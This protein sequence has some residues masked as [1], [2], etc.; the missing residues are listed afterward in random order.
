MLALM[1]ANA[2]Q[3]LR[4]ADR[5]IWIWAVAISIVAFLILFPMGYLAYGALHTMDGEFTLDAVQNVI[6]RD[7]TLRATINSVVMGLGATVLAVVLAV[8]MAWAVART[9]MPFKR[10][11][12]LLVV[13]SYVFPPFL[14]AFAYTL[15]FGPNRG[16]FNQWLSAVGLPTFN[17]YSR[18]GLIVAL[19]AH[20]YIFV[21]LTVSTALRRLDPEIEDAARIHGSGPLHTL[22]T[23][24]FPM[25]LPA[26]LS[27]C[28]LAFVVSQNSFGTHAFIGIPAG[29]RLL[30][31]E[32]YSLFTFPIRFS[33]A[34]VL[35]WILFGI[36]ALAT[37]IN[38]GLIGKR[39]Y[40]T[41]R[42][43]GMRP[44]VVRLGRFRWVAFG[45]CAF[46]LALT[47]IVPTIVILMVSFMRTWGR[48]AVAG[49]FTFDWYRF[50]FNYDL[51]REAVQ[52]SLWL[53]FTAAT[54]IIVLASII[55]YIIVRSEYKVR[56]LLSYLSII[57]LTVPGI[58]LAVGLI[59]A[60]INPPLALW[61][62]LTILFIAY[63]T[64]FYPIALQV[65]QSSVMQVEEE[66]EKSA[67]IHGASWFKAFRTILLPLI[68]PGLLAAWVM[69]FILSVRELAASIL[70][71]ASGTSVVSVVMFSFWE[72]G[73]LEAL[74]AFATLLM[75]LIILSYVA[76]TKL[77]GRDFFEQ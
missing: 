9:D 65:V 7:R 66:L 52:N 14:T 51:A 24:T 63:V 43:K 5:S 21:F 40:V 44:D 77:A 57:P 53:G 69:V 68:K 38:R 30:T 29:I 62:T 41:V 10:T 33:E 60:Y 47:L 49:N 4:R 45:Y 25:V 59:W 12:S 26:I 48:G 18:A 23:I 71:Q 8:P 35:A 39:Q 31:T 36:A 67:R 1:P 42:G 58:V 76:V 22:R 74:A 28:L 70:L 46:V 50:I 2:V 72:E 17:I 15:M 32:I 64:K 56:H 54:A 6:E 16:L 13:I 19:G 27:G 20:V 55:A 34:A 3:R 11:V 73:L 37:A 61:G 75:G